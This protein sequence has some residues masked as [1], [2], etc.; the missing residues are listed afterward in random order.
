MITVRKG[1]DRGHFDHGWLKTYHT[2]SFADYND[3]RFLGYRALR[4]INEDWIAPGEGFPRHPHKDM[5]IVTYVLD[6]TLEHKDSMGNGS[7][8]R[9]G[10]VQKMSA[11]MGIFHSEY[12]PSASEPVHLL[13]IW[14]FPEQKNLP[15]NY[16]QIKVDLVAQA[17]ELRL[18]GARAGGDGVVTIHQDLNLYAALLIHNQSVSLTL[19]RD[20]FAWLQMVRGEIVINDHRLIAGDGAAIEAESKLNFQALIMAEFLL[21]DL[22]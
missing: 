18:L 12:N 9:P 8:I 16:E 21:F 4:V 10:E 2:F 13:Q 17:G 3:P 7:V 22:A 19:P 6:G 14:I 5:E 20:R 11:G 1:Q 15:P